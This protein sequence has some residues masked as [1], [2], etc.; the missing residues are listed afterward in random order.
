MRSAWRSPSAICNAIFGDVVDHRTYVLAS[1]GDLMEGISQEAIALAGHLKLNRLIVLFDDN[2]ITIDGKLSLS[3]SVDQVKRFESAGWIAAR[4]DG[5]DPDAIAAALEEGA[6]APT[7]RRMI[8]CKTT[9]GFGAPTKAGSEKSHGSPLG[10]DEIKGARE[11]LGWTACAVRHPGRYSR[12]TG[13]RPASARKEARKAWD[14]QARRARARGEARE[15]ERRIDGELPKA[16]A[17]AVQER[18]GDAREDAEGHRHP[19]VFGIRAGKPRSGG[20]GNDRRLGR[21]HRLQQHPHQV[22]EGDHRHRIS[23]AASSITASAST[24]WRRP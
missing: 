9:I 21:P 12:A 1:D 2:G 23:P 10:A 14:K 3:D 16:L 8:A 20:A 7:G 22:D 11:K 18:E 4:I 24:A 6:R 15:F 19:R 17:D 13:A 5:H